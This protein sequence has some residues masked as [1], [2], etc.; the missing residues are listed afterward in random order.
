MSYQYVC[1]LDRTT[2]VLLINEQPPTVQSAQAEC[3]DELEKSIGAYVT[4]E[5]SDLYI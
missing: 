1:K 2:R 3:Q 4:F 5:L